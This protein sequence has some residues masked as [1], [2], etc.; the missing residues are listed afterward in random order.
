MDEPTCR[1]TLVSWVLLGD[2][3]AFKVLKPKLTD[4]LDHRDVDDRRRACERE[5]SL[6]R[7]MAPDVYE[8][9]GEIVL[10]GESVEPVVVMRRLPADRR[11]SALL[12]GP[13]EPHA[14][15]SVAR[16]IAAFHAATEP[17]ARSTAAGILSPEALL[18]RWTADV[19]GLDRA[20]AGGLGPQADELLRRVR[21]F[22]GGRAELLGERVASGLVRDGHGDLLADDV[23]CMDDGPRILDCLAFADGLRVNDVLADVAFLVMD[24]QRLGHPGAARQ[25]LRDYCEFSNEHHPGSLAHF[26]VAQRALV[27]AK[28]AA[29][30]TPGAVSTSE[31]DDLV[32]LALDHLRRVE[33]HLVLVGGLPGAGSSTLSQRLADELGWSVLSTDEVRRDLRLRDCDQPTEDAY[34][35]AT[36][37]TVYD[38]LRHRARHLLA[39]GTSVVLDASWTSAEERHEARVLAEATSSR[40]V[41]LRCVAPQALCRDRVATRTDPHGSEATPAVVDLLDRRADP[42]SEATDIDT[43]GRFELLQSAALWWSAAR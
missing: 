29:Q 7:R 31:I 20:V 27:R 43:S 33:V 24:L 9:V 13:H 10:D 21:T 41:E 8:G 25:L 17:V 30:R 34:A 4:V 35:P 28:V 6:N 2:D 16:R 23:F 14:V 12:G 22:L 32:S 15:R 37:A 19:D 11:L 38:E 1:E 26:Y 18:R 40:L 3:H 5:V 42:W 39:R 36:V